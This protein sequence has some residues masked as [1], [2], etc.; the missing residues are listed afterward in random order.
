MR[1]GRLMVSAAG[2]GHGK[3][4]VTMGLLQAMKER[5]IALQSFKCGP[6]YIDPGFH[7]RVLGVPCRNLDTFLMGE[8]D[9]LEE[10]SDAE[11]A[12][13]FAL[14][15]GA[16]GLFDG[17]GGG[18]AHSAFSTALLCGMPVVAVLDAG[19]EEDCAK[20]LKRLLERDTEGAIRGFL[21]NR[22]REEEYPSVIQS[23]RDT[24]SLN[25][26]AE[27]TFHFSGGGNKTRGMQDR[28]HEECREKG[29]GAGY[30]C[31][32]G[33]LPPL[34]E[35]VFPSRHL[36][37]VGA[38]ETEGFARRIMTI[39]NELERAGCVD[40]VL[41]LGQKEVFP[42]GK[43]L[44]PLEAGAGSPDLR[45]GA[46][47][48]MREA[49]APAAVHC[50]MRENTAPASA[51]YVP[52]AVSEKEKR[53]RI[54]VARDHAFSFVYQ[55]SLENL[56][57]AGAQLVFFSPLDDPCL[58]E[59]T[60]G[61][62][63][64]GGYPEL[65]ARDLEENRSMRISVRD[66]VIGGMPT[67]AECGGFLYLGEELCGEDGR[68]C[69]MAGV[70]RGRASKKDHLVRFGYLELM[71]E[72]G[73][74]LLFREGETVHAHEFHYWDT[75]VPG[76]DLLALKPSKNREWRCGFTGPKLYA[77]FP[78]LYLSAQRAER[79]VGACLAPIL[80]R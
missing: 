44:K 29:T 26:P 65:Y 52:E 80:L 43:T 47:R 3:S 79:F 56:E 72:R 34:P 66:A 12:G 13:L 36:G 27:I 5:G 1:A 70:L 59:G 48:K 18:G 4:V 58:P 41:A 39:A 46:G 8:E 22:C 14:A 49:T 40:A 23:I 71:Q 61:L 69:K 17:L 19:R 68:P 21:I 35:A 64:P 37:L 67:V 60:D 20:Q 63:L 31:A 42:Y 24:L 73:D 74:S 55:R 33:F 51:H 54:A 10:A 9:V 30:V 11:K 7:E 53:C 77:A 57:R 25:S 2:S 75:T 50:D 16:M 78:H 32:C 15:E 38:S 45:S 6:D 28:I 62:Y 76:D